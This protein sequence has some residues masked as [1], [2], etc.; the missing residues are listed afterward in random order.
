MCICVETF[1]VDA[2]VYK[3]MPLKS[4]QHGVNVK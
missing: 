1:Y 3:C 4:M 2:Q